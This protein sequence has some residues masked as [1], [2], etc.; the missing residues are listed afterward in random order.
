MPCLLLLQNVPPA[1]NNRSSDVPPDDTPHGGLAV[2]MYRLFLY[3]GAEIHRKQPI[4]IL[5]NYVN[6]DS[7]VMTSYDD[8]QFCSTS[9]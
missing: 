4:H 8:L 3:S 5:Q 7:H 9:L 1:T 2:L 6:V